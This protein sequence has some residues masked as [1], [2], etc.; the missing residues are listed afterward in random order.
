MNKEANAQAEALRYL[1]EAIT[2]KK[3]VY[4]VV[5]NIADK[6]KPKVKKVKK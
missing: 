5:K 6:K 1:I 3:V 2:G 4:K